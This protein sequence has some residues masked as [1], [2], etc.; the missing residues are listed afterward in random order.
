[1]ETMLTRSKSLDLSCQLH[2]GGLILT[3]EDK[4]IYQAITKDTKELSKPGGVKELEQTTTTFAVLTVFL[5]IQKVNMTD[6]QVI[7][8]LFEG[9]K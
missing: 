7:V 9:W 1:M 5:V 4:M 6:T 2:R 3:D 8:S